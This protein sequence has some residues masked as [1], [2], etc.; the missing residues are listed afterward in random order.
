MA[1]NHIT[2]RGAD[3]QEALLNAPDFLEE[4]VRSK[5]AGDQETDKRGPHLPRRGGLST[6]G[7]RPHQWR[8]V[9]SG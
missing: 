1:N 9:R 4:I 5:A 2:S 3:A 8:R 6:S 7:D